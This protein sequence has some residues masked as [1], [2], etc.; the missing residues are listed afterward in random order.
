MLEKNNRSFSCSRSQ[1]GHAKDSETQV[2][3]G[4]MSGS[5]GDKCPFIRVLDSLGLKCICT[6]D[7]K[8]TILSKETAVVLTCVIVVFMFVKFN[9]YLRIDININFFV[10][11]SDKFIYF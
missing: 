7:N 6:T 3:T 10:E 8:Y 5:Q 4:H 11:V 2:L 1:C 9:I